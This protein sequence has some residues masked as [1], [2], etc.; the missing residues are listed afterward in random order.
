MGCK[1]ISGSFVSANVLQFRPMGDDPNRIRELR[2]AHSPKMSQQKLGDAIGRSK[3]TIS[4][5]ESGKMELTLDYMR[6]IAK[7]FGVL[8]ADLLSQ[9]DNPYT[10]D[11]D[12]R[13]YVGR[14]IAADNAQRETLKRVTEAVAPSDPERKSA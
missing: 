13:E 9:A 1:G 7:V 4:D 8:P 3:M 6:R 12:A 11:A 5:L 14:Y 10:L 2:L